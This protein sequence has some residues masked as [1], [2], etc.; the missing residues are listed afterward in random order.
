MCFTVQ[1]Y[2]GLVSVGFSLIEVYHYVRLGQQSC[3]VVLYVDFNVE[4]YVLDRQ[5]DSL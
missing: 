5:T 3:L 4:M 2:I 1:P